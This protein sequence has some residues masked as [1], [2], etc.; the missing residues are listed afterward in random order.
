MA[1][2]QRE[3]QRSVEEFRIGSVSVAG[4]ENSWN[5]SKNIFV[6]ER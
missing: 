3:L 4:V 2:G 5:L 6:L 1:K